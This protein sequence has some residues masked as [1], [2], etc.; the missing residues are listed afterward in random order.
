M[1]GTGVSIRKETGRW[2]CA[3]CWER[4]PMGQAQILERLRAAGEE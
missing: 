2:F 4:S 3:A 1:Y